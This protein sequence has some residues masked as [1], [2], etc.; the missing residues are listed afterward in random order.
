MVTTLE[1]EMSLKNDEI[2]ELTKGSKLLA[3]EN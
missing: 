2:M 1:K 3:A